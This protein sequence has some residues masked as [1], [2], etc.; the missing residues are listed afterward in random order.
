V[1]VGVG[2]G[3]GLKVIGGSGTDGRG[4]GSKV[5]VGRGVPLG[6]GRGGPLGLGVGVLVGLGEGDGLGQVSSTRFHV[7]RPYECVP[8]FASSIH[9]CVYWRHT[10]W[11]TS[12]MRM[13]TLRVP[14]GLTQ[15]STYHVSVVRGSV[16][17]RNSS[18]LVNGVS[19]D[20]S[21]P[22]P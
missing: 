10:L 21:K 5:P 15:P 3:A 8:F 11:P 20:G 19:F 13:P 12:W 4:N 18:V 17:R 14:S 22:E 6:E 1:R 16:P 7:Y 2:V 9:F